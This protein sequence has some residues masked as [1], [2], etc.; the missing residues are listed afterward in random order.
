MLKSSQSTDFPLLRAKSIKIVQSKDQSP[1]YVGYLLCNFPYSQE[2]DSTRVDEVVGPIEMWEQPESGGVFEVCVH[3]VN[4]NKSVFNKIKQHILEQSALLMTDTSEV[5]I[6]RSIIAKGY[7]WDHILQ[8]M[9]HSSIVNS[10][11]TQA[12]IEIFNYSKATLYYKPQEVTP[13]VNELHEELIPAPLDIIEATRDKVYT[14][15]LSMV[16]NTSTMY[17]DGEKSNFIFDIAKMIK[18]TKSSPF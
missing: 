7:K 12:V 2:D 15:V 9:Q 17:V 14:T 1:D 18:H 10:I 4:A 16:K 8:M 11:V 3:H 6:L 13:A 5:T